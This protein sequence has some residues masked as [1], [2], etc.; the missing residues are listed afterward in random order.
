MPLPS[1]WINNLFGRLALRY[2]TRFEAQYAG[3]DIGAVKAD[4]AD[5]LDGFRGNEIGYAL[6]YLPVDKPP[7]AMQFRDICRRSPSPDLPK[8]PPGPPAS[9]ERVQEAMQ[10]IK[11]AEHKWSGMSLAARCIEN[12]ERIV[13]ERGGKISSAQKSMLASCRSRLN[14]GPAE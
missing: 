3:L 14:L 2:G 9:P 13:A 12:I 8:L 10:K 11:P 7:N 5:M 4:W 1:S 6:K